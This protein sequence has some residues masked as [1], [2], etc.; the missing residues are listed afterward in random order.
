MT[1]FRKYPSDSLL[2]IVMAGIAWLMSNC[3][4]YVLFVLSVRF[5]EQVM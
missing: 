4:G 3:I 2:F 5:Q 1:V